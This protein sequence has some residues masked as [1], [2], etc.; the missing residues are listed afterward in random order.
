MN[1]GRYLMAKMVDNVNFE[2]TI[3]DPEGR[4]G[5]SILLTLKVNKFKWMNSLRDN[6]INNK[7]STR[8]I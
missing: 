5:D 6:L 1:D 7:E 8:V 4:R 2:V 3:Y